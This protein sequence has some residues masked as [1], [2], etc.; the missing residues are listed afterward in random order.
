RNHYCAVARNPELWKFM[1]FMSKPIRIG[2]VGSQFIC[3]IH[4]ESIKRCADAEL[5]AIASPT[6]DHAKSFAARFEIPHHFTDYRKML[7]LPEL[8]V[9]LLGVPNHLH[10]QITLDAVAAG[11]HV[12]VEKPLCM[13]LREADQLIAGSKKAKRKL[14]YAAELCFKPKYVRMYELLK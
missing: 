14:M 8:D 13:N 1:G 7:K 5:F 4:A 3:S 10:C 2:L 6:K 9:V 12:I 11:K